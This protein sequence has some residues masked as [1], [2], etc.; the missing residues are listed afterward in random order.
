MPGATIRKA[1]LNWLLAGERTAFSV[2][3]A[4]SIAI[5]VVLPA[6]VASFSAIRISSGLAPWFAAW[7]CFQRC[8]CC[9]CLGATSVSQIAVSAASTWQKNGRTDSNS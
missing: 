1:R 3:Q 6:P 4:I 2:C 9:F 8:A 7:M 5:T